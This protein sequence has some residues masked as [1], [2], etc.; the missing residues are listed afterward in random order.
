MDKRS[1]RGGKFACVHLR[2]GDYARGRGSRAP[3]IEGAAEQVG[4]A[5]TR[6]G[7]ET[8][9]VATDA[10]VQEWQ[11]FKKGLEKFKVVRFDPS[12]DELKNFGDGGVAIIDQVRYSN[13]NS[14]TIFARIGNKSI[15]PRFRL[16]VDMLSTSLGL[17][18][19]PLHS[20]KCHYDEQQSANCTNFLYSGFRR[21][22]R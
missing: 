4:Q 18:I 7:L 9:F 20:G 15:S 5:L 3:T 14:C 13:N 21:R 1:P 2:R 6:R 11:R 10:D 8:L 17:K 22:E 12:K 16:C 19:P